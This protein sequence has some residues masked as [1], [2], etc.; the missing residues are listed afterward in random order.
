MI[1]T[2]LIQQQKY[3][4]AVKYLS[5]GQRDL[6]GVQ[7]QR[8][9]ANEYINAVLTKYGDQCKLNY[10]EYKAEAETAKLLPCPELCFSIM[11]DNAL[12]NAYEATSQ[13]PL[14]QRYIRLSLKQ[15]DNKLL[16][17][18]KNTYLATPKFVN[19]I[20][21]SAKANHG[22]GTQSIIYNCNKL[23]GQCKFSL[24][25]NMFVLQIIV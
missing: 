21:V 13:L 23:G 25:N 4:E 12:E 18:L 24:E 5:D 8:Y 14:G 16:L 22:I 3:E 10:I 11:L 9:C 20:P 7:L 17:S 1:C 2:T 6:D 15:K 19:D